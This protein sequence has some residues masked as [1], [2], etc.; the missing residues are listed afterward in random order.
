VLPTCNR[1][2]PRW[3]FARCEV[4]HYHVADSD[5]SFSNSTETGWTVYYGILDSTAITIRHAS[6]FL[7]NLS[8][9]SAYQRIPWLQYCAGL[10]TSGTNVK[11]CYYLMIS[12][13]TLPETIQMSVGVQ[14][15]VKSQFWRTIVIL[16]MQSGPEAISS[17]IF[18]RSTQPTN[19]AYFEAYQQSECSD[20]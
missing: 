14:Q 15:S 17:T 4:L 11:L 2:K 18:N 9:L 16:V 20:Y 10:E 6:V 13:Q 19:T 1:R 7:Q 5:P 12:H 8:K 3:Q